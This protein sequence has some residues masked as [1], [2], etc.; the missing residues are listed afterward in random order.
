MVA[1]IQDT[2]PQGRY[3][4]RIVRSQ[5]TGHS[6]FLDFAIIGGAYDGRVI[7]KQL[8]LHS[9]DGNKKGKARSEL[10]QICLAVGVMAP[11]DSSELHNI[12]MVIHVGTDKRRNTVLAYSSSRK[13]CASASPGPRR[14]QLTRA[15]DIE[16]RPPDWLLRGMLERDT[17][18]RSEEHTSELQSH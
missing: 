4:A 8:P 7:A 1:T 14:L 12:P 5:F 6:L 10:S 13:Q 2:I 3:E 18:A 15:A 16:I 9:S 17:F 11:K